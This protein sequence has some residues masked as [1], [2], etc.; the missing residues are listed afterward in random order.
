VAKAAVVRRIAARI[1][2]STVAHTLKRLEYV[3]SYPFRSERRKV[4]GSVPR[5]ATA[6]IIP[7]H[8]AGRHPQ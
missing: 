8:G 6:G 4:A 2:A 5:Y 7:R 1:A 3:I